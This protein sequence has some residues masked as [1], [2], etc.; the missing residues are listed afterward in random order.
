MTFKPIA[1]VDLEKIPTE[2]RGRWIVLWDGDCGFCR[3]SVEWVKS[4]DKQNRLI[5]APYQAHKHWLPDG[6]YSLSSKQVHLMSPSGEFWGGSEAAQKILEIIDY[7]KL[8]AFLGLPFA[9]LLNDWGYRLVA[10]NR[11]LFSKLFFR[12]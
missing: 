9:R 11:I 1:K 8:S 4:E 7:K 6:V 5:A 10:R 2:F 12:K 3:R